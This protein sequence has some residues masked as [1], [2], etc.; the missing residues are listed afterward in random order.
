MKIY[1]FAATLYFL[2][3]HLVMSRRSNHTDGLNPIQKHDA[4]KDTVKSV[5]TDRRLRTN[6]VGIIK[7]WGNCQKRT[8]RKLQ[9]HQFKNNVDIKTL[10]QLVSYCKTIAMRL[11]GF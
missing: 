2:A 7:R 1:G 4:Q 5:T 8:G 9:F 11:G 6:V 3:F 10:Q